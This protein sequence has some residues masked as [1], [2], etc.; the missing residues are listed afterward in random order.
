MGG[1][2][3][4]GRGHVAGRKAGPQI[5]TEPRRYAAFTPAVV[6][7]VRLPEAEDKARKDRHFPDHLPANDPRSQ[8]AT[9]SDSL[10][11]VIP[12]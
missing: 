7:F 5:E 6:P 4:Q 9:R 8:L 10:V 1:L 3:E 12:T 11:A 2:A